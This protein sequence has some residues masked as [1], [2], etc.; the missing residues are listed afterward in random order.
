MLCHCALGAKQ[1]LVAYCTCWHSTSCGAAPS[2]P[3]DLCKLSQYESNPTLSSMRATAN[4]RLQ[5]CPAGMHLRRSLVCKRSCV[6]RRAGGFNPIYSKT[7]PQNLNSLVKLCQVRSA[8]IK[9][10]LW[11]G[12][13]QANLRRSV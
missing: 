13:V 2:H 5:V 9:V 10:G 3:W 7:K 4:A 8:Q 1:H 6:N 12:L 11:F